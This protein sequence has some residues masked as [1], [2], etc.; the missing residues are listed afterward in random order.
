M[1]YKMSLVG[2]KHEGTVIS[3]PLVPAKGSTLKIQ[4]LHKETFEVRITDVQY[5]IRPNTFA[6]NLVVEDV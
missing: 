3:L 2:T 5:D 4:Q 6:V 1:L